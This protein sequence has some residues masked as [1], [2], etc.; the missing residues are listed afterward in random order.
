MPHSLLSRYPLGRII[1]K[2]FRQQLH[3]HGV[4]VR[5]QVRKVLGDRVHGHV[6]L[7]LG[8][9]GDPRV[10][11]AGGSPQ[12]AEDAVQLVPLG[13]AHYQRATVRHLS[14]NAADAPDVHWCGVLPG[15]HEHVRSAVPQSHHFVRVAAHGDAKGAGQAEIRQLQLALAVDEQ[16]LRLQVP[17]EHTVVMAEGDPPK[18]LVQE[19]LDNHRFQPVFTDI[20]ILFQVLVQVLKNQC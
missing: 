7:P 18:Q 11:L 8:Q 20:Q 15:P 13:G 14:K 3:A 17:V 6:L 19:G 2:H 16:V 10:D 12:L 4:E 1:T 9:L 5:N